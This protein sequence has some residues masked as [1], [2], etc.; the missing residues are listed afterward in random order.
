MNATTTRKLCSSEQSSNPTPYKASGDDSPNTSSN[1]TSGLS[2]TTAVSFSTAASSNYTSKRI[3]YHTQYYSLTTFIP[4][5]AS[6][7]RSI[8]TNFPASWKPPPSTASGTPLPCTGSCGTSI[9]NTLP[10]QNGPCQAGRSTTW[11]NAP[12]PA[13]LPLGPPGT[14]PHQYHPRSCGVPLNNG[15][16]NVTLQSWQ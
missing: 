4:T 6:S 8:V 16:T 3:Q 2:S 7:N 13:T 1:L 11:A 10:Q 14:D 9:S 15:L 12:P 5:S